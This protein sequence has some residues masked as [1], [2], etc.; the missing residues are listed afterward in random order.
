MSSQNNNAAPNAAALQQRPSQTSQNQNT[1]RNTNSSQQ[2][3]NKTLRSQKRQP[4]YLSRPIYDLRFQLVNRNE[5]SRVPVLPGALF[6]ALN[7]AGSPFYNAVRAANFQDNILHISITDIDKEVI[8]RDRLDFLNA[9]FDVTFRIQE[10]Y[11]FFIEAGDISDDLKTLSDKNGVRV[12]DVTNFKGSWFV[13]VATL[14]DAF[15]IVAR[16][17]FCAQNAEFSCR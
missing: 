10:N 1:A 4:A 17:R 5:A 8:F 7:Q 6:A 12:V 3:P 11:V 16:G 14:Q 13:S 9:L 2:R 15:K